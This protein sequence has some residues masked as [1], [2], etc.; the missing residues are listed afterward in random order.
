MDIKHAVII[1]KN[2]LSWMKCIYF[3]PYYP[4]QNSAHALIWKS[5]YLFFVWKLLQVCLTYVRCG[6][7][8]SVHQ[9]RPREGGMQ[10]RGQNRDKCEDEWWRW[11]C[12]WVRGEAVQVCW[13]E[14]THG[15]CV[16]VWEVRRNSA[17]E[18]DPFSETLLHRTSITFERLCWSDT[19]S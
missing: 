9:L 10:L 12:V 17:R 6:I 19:G 15:R 5:N 8:P 1:P 16:R 18:S 11:T 13:W 3:L 4:S 14:V 2:C 7:T